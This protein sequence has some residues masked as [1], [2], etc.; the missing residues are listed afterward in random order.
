M[1]IA[2]IILIYVQPV[3]FSEWELP[4][5]WLPGLGNMELQTQTHRPTNGKEELMKDSRTG[6]LK[7]CIITENVC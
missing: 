6:S 4:K 3:P 1:I 7:L 5:N 2:A